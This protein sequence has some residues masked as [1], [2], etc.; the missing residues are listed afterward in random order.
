MR[1]LVI[2]TTDWTRHPVPNRLNFIFDILA[3]DHEV[4]VLHFNLRK[5]SAVSPRKTHCT[6]IESGPIPVKD[7]SLYY[8]LNAPFHFATILKVVK[9][10]K[11]DIIVSANILPSLMTGWFTTPVVFDYLDHLEESASVYYQGSFAGE[12]I[13]MVVHHITIR[14][15]RKARSIITVTGSFRNYLTSLGFSSVHIVPNGVDTSVL[16]LVSGKEAKTVLAALPSLEVTLL[17]VGPGLFTDYGEKIRR[18]AD[19]LHVANRVIFTGQVPFNEL[20]LYISAMDIGLNPLKHMAK[21]EMTVG[22]KIFNYLSCGRPVLSSRMPAIEKMLGDSIFY[23][24]NV[25]SFISQVNTILSHPGDAVSYRNLALRYDWRNIAK[26]YEK[27]LNEFALK[28][29]NG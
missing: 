13:R 18:M 26:E 22:G 24:D 16:S 19:K 20:G 7:P 3:R 4:F 21:N 23:F 8:V 6:L 2:P 14:N 15:L 12:V 17:V 25:S 9:R 28:P 10:K 5:F 29:I 11:I 27:V 1:I